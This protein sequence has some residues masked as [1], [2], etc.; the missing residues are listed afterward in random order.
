[1][2]PETQGKSTQ[3]GFSVTYRE[4]GIIVYHL[5]DVRRSTIDTWVEIS[6]QHEAEALAENRHLRRVMDIREA[7]FPTPYSTIKTAD[8]AKNSAHELRKSF[9]ILVRDSMSGEIIRNAM[10]HINK[11]VD[12]TRLFTDE[13][14]ALDWLNDRLTELGE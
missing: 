4:D 11:W 3:T 8:L 9:A 6:H 2:M 13:Q 7:G 5:A 12:S 14:D 10:R 1:M